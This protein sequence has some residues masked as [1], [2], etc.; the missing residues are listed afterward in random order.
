MTDSNG[1]PIIPEKLLSQ[2]AHL[3]NWYRPITVI[4]IYIVLS[5][6][7]GL[8][9]TLYL[10]AVLAQWGLALF[11]GEP[12]Q[13]LQGVINKVNDYIHQLMQ[14]LAAETDDRPFP[15]SMLP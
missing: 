12:S 7:G 15:F 2:F 3:P 13:A 8:L 4:G 9:V 14:Y 1:K 10:L 6:V 5:M 11:M